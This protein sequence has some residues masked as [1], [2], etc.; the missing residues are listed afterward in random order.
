[1]SYGVVTNILNTGPHSPGR[2][3]NLQIPP[4]SCYRLLYH[5]FFESDPP[6][7]GQTRGT[8]PNL[9]VLLRQCNR[10]QQQPLSQPAYGPPAGSP[11]M[12]L[13]QLGPRI[14]SMDSK[15][16]VLG[17]VPSPAAIASLPR[18]IR[19]P[20]RAAPVLAPA[21]VASRRHHHTSCSIGGFHGCNSSCGAV[22]SI[23]PGDRQH[24]RSTTPPYGLCRS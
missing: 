2:S 23:E 14:G 21:C 19:V 9:N 11:H 4:D 18:G 3:C 5:N 13:P 12:V 24:E 22:S 20:C 17:A 8:N 7:F 15:P 1:M 10:G 6:S 16:R